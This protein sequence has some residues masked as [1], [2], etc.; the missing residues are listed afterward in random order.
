[1]IYRLKLCQDHYYTLLRLADELN[2]RGRNPSTMLQCRHPAGR[3]GT[4]SGA[5][6]A[7][8]QTADNLVAL[9]MAGSLAG[10][11]GAVRPID[12]R[13]RIVV[14]AAAM[15]CAASILVIYKTLR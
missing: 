12:E 9:Y 15:I 14:N 3:E 10:M 11:T 4:S 2:S 7:H 8:K 1:M 13:L 5:V 6:V